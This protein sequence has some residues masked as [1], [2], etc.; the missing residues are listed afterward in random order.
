MS[1]GGTKPEVGRDDWDSHWSAYRAAA[2]INPANRFRRR[3]IFDSLALGAGPIR[4]VDIGSGPGELLA[5]VRAAHP[6]AEL[7][8]IELSREGIAAA[9]RL[10]PDARF[11]QRDLS[12]P[13]A[14]P[15]EFQ[16]W[17]THAVCSE[18]LEHLDDPVEFLRNVRPVLGP[19]CRLVI[20]VPG[21][22]MSAFDRSIGHRRHFT[23][24]ALEELLRAAGLTVEWTSG[25]GF[26]FFNLY[27]LAVIARGDALA[28]DIGQSTGLPWTARAAMAGFD[29]LFRLS[30][31]AGTRGWQIAACARNTG[32]SGTAR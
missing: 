12:V 7:L 26:P 14:L 31:T 9:Q 5:A 15:D 17:A 1:N 20:T 2:E 23:A 27:R 13:G 30:R 19:S 29:Q 8:G 24:A 16:G 4:L 10:L 25:A 28:R 6:H 11:I 3:L 32:N 21:G 22:P 18:V